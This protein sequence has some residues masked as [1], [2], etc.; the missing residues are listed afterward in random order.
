MNDTQER[1][2]ARGLWRYGNCFAIMGAVREAL[3]RAGRHD[4]FETYK[5]EATSGDYDN[6]IQVTMR[7]AVEDDE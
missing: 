4:E 5:E 3:R 1:V 2:V 6:L 7:W